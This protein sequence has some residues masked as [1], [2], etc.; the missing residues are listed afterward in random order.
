MARAVRFLRANS[1]AGNAQA[2][3]IVGPRVGRAGRSPWTGTPGPPGPR[4]TWVSNRRIK[5]AGPERSRL[6][7]WARNAFAGPTSG[8]SR[9][10]G[11]AREGFPRYSRAGRG[12]ASILPVSQK[13]P[14]FIPEELGRR[15]KRAPDSFRASPDG[16][17][18]ATREGR[19]VSTP[20]A[21]R[22]HRRR[23]TGGRAGWKN[24]IGLARSSSET[25]TPYPGDS[26]PS[27]S[28]DELSRGRG[29]AR[30]VGHVAVIFVS[31]RRR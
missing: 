18:S 30:R 12:G 27:R 24:P 6:A 1:G 4:S 22:I 26:G 2:W 20:R 25:S 14:M 11:A 10:I 5:E 29:P 8:P 16:L 13:S 15:R 19:V 23:R 31:P 9:N 7:P 28:S 17:S 21:T 3:G